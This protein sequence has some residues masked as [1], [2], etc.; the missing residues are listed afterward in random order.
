MKDSEYY[1]NLE[2]NI[3]E[4]L[5]LNVEEKKETEK[6][7]NKKRFKAWLKDLISSYTVEIKMDVKRGDF[8]NALR[9]NI[10]K[11]FCEELVCMISCPDI[12][13]LDWVESD[14]RF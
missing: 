9:K 2:F 4:N 11:E 1:I 12:Y 13:E 3:E 6:M 10:E 5:E 7:I 8:E 14:W